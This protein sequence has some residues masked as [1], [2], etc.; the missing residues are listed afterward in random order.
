M[1]AHQDRH[2]NQEQPLASPGRSGTCQVRGHDLGIW[3][4]EISPGAEIQITGPVPPSI[5]S[6]DRMIE[7]WSGAIAQSAGVFS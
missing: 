3:L 7:F 4:S 2:L 5:A 6:S 1:T